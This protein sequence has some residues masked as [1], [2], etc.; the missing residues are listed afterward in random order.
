[1]CN[2]LNQRFKVCYCIREKF[3]KLNL[4]SHLIIV[5]NCFKSN[6]EIASKL[7][8]THENL[9][10][11]DRED[12]HTFKNHHIIT[13]ALETRQAAMCATARAV[14]FYN[15]CKVTGAV[16]YKWH[17]LT[18]KRSEHKLANLTI[19]NRLEGYR[20]YNLHY[21]IILP[22]VHAVLLLAL[23]SHTRTAHLAHA[24]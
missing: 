16:A 5:I 15:A 12:V 7:F 14:T 20:I 1:M 11:L 18:V 4:H 19:W 3:S 24:K 10:Y 6:K 13:T 23:K 2:L 9:L 8:E 21:H 22:D 17:G